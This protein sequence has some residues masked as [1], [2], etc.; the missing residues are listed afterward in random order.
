MSP[1]IFYTNYKT[2]TVG[3]VN[4]DFNSLGSALF[5]ITDNNINTRYLIKIESG[6]SEMEFGSRGAKFELI[7]TENFILPPTQAFCIDIVQ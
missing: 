2:L 5:S 6:I 1:S 7:P 3:K 4:C